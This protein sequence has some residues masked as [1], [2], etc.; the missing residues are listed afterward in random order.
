[1][2]RH[3]HQRSPEQ[4]LLSWALAGNARRLICS[5]ALKLCD[6]VQSHSVRALSMCTLRKNHTLPFLPSVNF[7]P[8]VMCS[9]SPKQVY[10]MN[11]AGVIK[12]SL[13]TK[14]LAGEPGTWEELYWRHCAGADRACA[15]G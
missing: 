13:G 14:S 11:Q 15:G 5:Q 6:T 8:C 10:L 3:A 9:R 2:Q 12:L 7:C 4:C 1:M